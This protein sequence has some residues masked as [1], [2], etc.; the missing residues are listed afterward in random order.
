MHRDDRGDEERGEAVRAPRKAR[1]HDRG[2]QHLVRV[3]VRVRVR[4]GVGVGVR[5]RVGVRIRIR[6]RIRVRVRIR[7]R[8]LPRGRR[9]G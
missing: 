1:E 7:A 9:P 3:R 4:A 6:V 8:V 2:G 5:A